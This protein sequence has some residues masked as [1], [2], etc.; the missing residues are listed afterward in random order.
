MPLDNFE[1]ASE[2]CTHH[3]ERVWQISYL[4]LHI[5]KLSI[6]FYHLQ[7]LAASHWLHLPQDVWSAFET[8]QTPLG[9]D[10]DEQDEV[11]TVIDEEW[12]L[13]KAKFDQDQD[14]AALFQRWVCLQVSPWIALYTV[15]NPT[16]DD[17]LTDPVVF[18][19]IAVAKCTGSKMENWET[20]I[21]NLAVMAPQLLSGVSFDGEHVIDHL[22]QCVKDYSGEKGV[23]GI[24]RV[25]ENYDPKYFGTLTVRWFWWHSLYAWTSVLL[26]QSTAGHFK[27]SPVELPSWLLKAISA[28]IM[29]QLRY[30]LCL[31]IKIMMHPPFEKT[32]SQHSSNQSDS[33]LSI[34]S[35][36]S[37]FSVDD[38]L[39][40]VCAIDT[41]PPSESEPEQ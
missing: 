41:G 18:K 17:K 27:A 16:E 13:L 10:K 33:G 26:I 19:F 2:A 9:G 30:S 34:T 23:D 37:D 40:V 8:G 5:A 25:F 7:A 35:T 29:E 15:S 4:L 1:A 20:V 21:R 11:K 39:P 28:K 3:A 38:G 12:E 6:F 31:E 22:K 32:H 36:V 14:H 24:M